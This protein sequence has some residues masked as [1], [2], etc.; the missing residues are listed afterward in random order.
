MKGAEIMTK[1]KNFLA[2]GEILCRYDCFLLDT[3]RKIEYT[4]AMKTFLCENGMYYIYAYYYCD[5]ERI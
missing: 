1:C 4:L 3:R 2:A 5:G